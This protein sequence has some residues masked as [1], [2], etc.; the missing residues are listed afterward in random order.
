MSSSPMKTI[1][2]ILLIL[3]FVPATA[4]AK[5]T[6]LQQRIDAQR[7]KAEALQAQL[8]AKKQ[9]L[10]AA[11]VKVQGLQTQLNE[12]NTAIDQVSAHLN[13]V[14]AQEH[15]TQRKADWNTVQLRAAQRRYL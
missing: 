14:N 6:T 8:H 12:T 11:T 1:L 5:G 2:C 10:N 3:V 13:D 4:G 15:S 9:Q 7:R